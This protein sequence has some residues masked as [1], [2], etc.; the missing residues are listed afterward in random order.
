MTHRI[1]H[2]LQKYLLNPP[3]KVARIGVAGNNR[4]DKP[5][6]H[7]AGQWEIAEESLGCCETAARMCRS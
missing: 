7:E 4:G 5:G 2:T 1:V 3:M 6:S